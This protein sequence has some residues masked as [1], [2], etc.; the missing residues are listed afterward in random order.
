MPFSIQLRTINVLKWFLLS[1]A[2]KNNWTLSKAEIIQRCEPFQLFHSHQF[3]SVFAYCFSLAEKK[4]ETK[5]INWKQLR[6]GW[7]ELGDG[8]VVQ[9]KRFNYFFIVSKQIWIS[10][11]NANSSVWLTHDPDCVWMCLCIVA[12]N[13]SWCR[14]YHSRVDSSIVRPVTTMPFL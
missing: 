12:A 3:V 6:T 11:K 2:P 4:T 8:S 1:L 5:L 7:C 13:F 10:R 9:S 14:L